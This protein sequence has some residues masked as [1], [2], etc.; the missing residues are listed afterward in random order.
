[1]GKY[2]N[3]QRLISTHYRDL[4]FNIQHALYYIFTLEK[5]R[6][7][8]NKVSASVRSVGRILNTCSFLTYLLSAYPDGGGL[9]CLAAVLPLVPGAGAPLGRQRTRHHQRLGFR[10][11]AVRI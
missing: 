4:L 10:F 7:S 6:L 11:S 1:M 8:Q 2:C 5:I 3:R 9:L